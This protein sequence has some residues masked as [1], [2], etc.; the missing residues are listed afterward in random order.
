MSGEGRQDA[1]AA[2]GAI[3]ASLISQQEGDH[4]GVVEA[5]MSESSSP[6]R[7]PDFQCRK[8]GE[9]GNAAPGSQDSDPAAPALADL[10]IGLRSDKMQPYRG[11]SRRNLSNIGNR[12]SA[13]EI[14]GGMF[15]RI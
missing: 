6:L 15:V 12:R 3:Q 5:G 10:N 1:G 14:L 11:T 2:D 8:L 9:E 7:V 4:G 13:S